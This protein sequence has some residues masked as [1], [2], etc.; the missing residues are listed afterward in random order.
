MISMRFNGFS[1]VFMGFH[2]FL[3]LFQVSAEDVGRPGGISQHITSHLVASS[4]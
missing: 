1:W 4:G 3:W 2:E